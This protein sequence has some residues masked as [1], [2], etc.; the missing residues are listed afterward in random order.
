MNN[1]WV[2]DRWIH[3]EW[4]TFFSFGVFSLIDLKRYVSFSL[5]IGPL[6][7]AFEWAKHA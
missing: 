1:R 7:F 5:I 4:T 3:W 2:F 6:T